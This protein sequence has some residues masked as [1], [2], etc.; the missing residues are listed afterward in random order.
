MS[1]SCDFQPNIIL[2][3]LKSIAKTET[4]DYNKRRNITK[5]LPKIKY[6]RKALAFRI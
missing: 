3:K 4:H 2:I 1:L 5:K 6:D